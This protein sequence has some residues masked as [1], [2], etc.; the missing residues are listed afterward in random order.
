[1]PAIKNI[2]RDQVD[3]IVEMY[4]NKIPLFE[5][6]KKFNVSGNSVKHHLI[7]RNVYIKGHYNR[8]EKEKQDIIDLY[9]KNLPLKEI[10]DMFKIS[11]DAISSLIRKSGIKITPSERKKITKRLNITEQDI[12]Y[13]YNKEKNLNILAKKFKT[14]DTTI[15]SILQRNGIKNIGLK[16]HKINKFKS[17]KD[18]IFKYYYEKFYSMQEIADEYNIG[19]T[20]VANWMK[21]WGWDRRHKYENTS[22]ERFIEE[23][24]EKNEIEFIKQFE[25]KPFKYDFLLSNYNLILEINGDYWHGN[26]LIFEDNKF[27]FIQKKNI[28]RDLSKFKK[29]KYK[30]YNILYIWES[31]I[32]K[33]P[34]IVEKKL[35]RNIS[36]NY[37]HNSHRNFLLNS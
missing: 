33:H 3:I 17:D 29:T 34:K 23:I 21:K 15:R 8:S 2:T 22:I 9:N 7:K 19:L 27:D 35:L 12:V 5:I 26:P 6:G 10:S 18:K 32:T 20:S 1:M 13:A 4:L 25:I 37:S 28:A 11:C 36:L 16:N 31:E 30:K 14:S 24:L